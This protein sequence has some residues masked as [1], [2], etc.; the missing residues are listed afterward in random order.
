MYLCQ[1]LSFFLLFSAHIFSPFIIKLWNLNLEKSNRDQPN[2]GNCHIFDVYKNYTKVGI[3]KFFW[4]IFMMVGKRYILQVSCMPSLNYLTLCQATAL[5]TNY[6]YTRKPD[7]SYV[8]AK[9]VVIRDGITNDPNNSLQ[10]CDAIQR[11][12]H[13][14]LAHQLLWFFGRCID[15]PSEQTF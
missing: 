4:S 2:F 7:A 14:E 8:T 10:K 3:T 1:N 9:G 5:H 15:S 13:L 11:A 6:P 12:G